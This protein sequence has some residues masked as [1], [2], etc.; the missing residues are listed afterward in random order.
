MMLSRR[1]AQLKT[2]EEILKLKEANE[3][4]EDKIRHILLND[5]DSE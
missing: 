3:E 5:D 4:S 1:F 2:Q